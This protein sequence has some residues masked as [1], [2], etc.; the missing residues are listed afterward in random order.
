MF[1]A[2][3][4]CWMTGRAQDDRTTPAFGGGERLVYTVSYRAAMWPNTDMGTVV[5]TVDE[6]E[7]D[8]VPALRISAR[9]TVKG[10]FSWFY[11][12]RRPLPQLAAQFGYAAGEGRGRTVGGGLPL[13]ERF[14]L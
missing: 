13:F 8:G 14:R 6:D 7:A 11:K 5:L 10:M 12:A 4:F 9:A 3:V 1:A 2:V